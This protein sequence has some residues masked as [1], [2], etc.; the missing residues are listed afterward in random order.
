M[1]RFERLQL[2]P[3]PVFPHESTLRAAGRDADGSRSERRRRA[4]A[5]AKVDTWRRRSREN[6]C[7]TRSRAW[8][9]VIS[10]LFGELPKIKSK[11]RFQRWKAAMAGREEFITDSRYSETFLAKMQNLPLKLGVVLPSSMLKNTDFLRLAVAGV[12][13]VGL[14]IGK[15]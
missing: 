4:R 6:D 7:A 9:G 3:G 8:A 10:L 15:A 5:R 12:S 1:Q 11:P 14:C 2:C 13:W